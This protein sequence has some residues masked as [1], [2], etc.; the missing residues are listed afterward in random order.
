MVSGYKEKSPIMIK[1]TSI[2]SLLGQV[3]NRGLI[4]TA[5]AAVSSLAVYGNE[6][7]RSQ[8]AADDYKPDKFIK[9]SAQM[10]LSSIKLAE[11]GSEKASSDQLKEFASKV[12][13]EHKKIQERL[14]DVAK[15]KDVSI[16]TS[17][18][19]KHQEKHQEIHSRLQQLSGAQ[20]DQEFAR[21]MVKGHHIGVNKLEKAS[22]KVEDSELKE[23]VNSTL[24]ELKDHK[25][26][27][28]SV[29]KAVGLSE[30]SIAALE[31]E[32]EEQAVGTPGRAIVIE[33][34]IIIEPAQPGQQQDS[35]QEA[36]PQ[37][38]RQEAS[39]QSPARPQQ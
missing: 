15:K 26:E 8:A 30:T 12:K 24:S 22:E 11:L 33:R 38:S 14:K 37:D 36:S 23:F 20:F 7:H 6:H 1:Q 27:A 3:L 32:E 16:P 13:T 25:K 17:L 10:N 19:G 18:E 5:I 39:P 34:G 31:R 35:G 9:E 28:R 4:I 29:A 21:V 2:V